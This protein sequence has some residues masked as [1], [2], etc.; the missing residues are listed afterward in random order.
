[1]VKLAIFFAGILKYC[2]QFALEGVVT[3]AESIKDNKYISGKYWK[4]LFVASIAIPHKS[5]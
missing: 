4:K 2:L 3:F 5:A 1:M